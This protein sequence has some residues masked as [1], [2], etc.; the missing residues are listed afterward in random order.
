[1]RTERRLIQSPHFV[2]RAVECTDDHG[3]W[4]APETAPGAQIVL[5]RRGRSEPADR[6]REAVLADEPGC[7]NL[8]ALSR[9]LGTSPS[10]LSHTFRHHVGMPLGR[11]RNRVR[12]SRALT[13]LDQ[14]ET[15]LAALAAGLGFSDQA[16]LT[17]VMRG[18]P[19]HT[20]GRVRALLGAVTSSEPQRR[21]A[22]ATRP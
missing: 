16:H 4:S 2:L 6:A 9:R 17:R 12:V 5:V 7:G 3:G 1:M 11:Y 22:A 21:R 15:D 20:P 18:E 13:R 10:H 8:V 14:G 19:G